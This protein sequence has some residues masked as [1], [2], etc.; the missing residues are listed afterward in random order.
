[1]TVQIDGHVLA[2]T[3][4]AGSVKLSPEHDTL[5]DIKVTNNG[6]VPV[7]VRTLRL[8]GQVMGLQFFAYNTGVGAT[9]GA[10]ETESRQ[11]LL[12]LS[13]LNDQA[14]GFM[15]GTVKAVDA[16]HHVVAEQHGLVDVRGSL[17]S[18][19][20]LF[21]LSVALLTALLFLEV[22]L[23]LARELLPTNRWRRATRF[24]TPGLGLGLVINFTLAATR[25]FA[26][27]MGRWFG[28]AVVSAVAMFV[29]GYLTPTPGTEAPE[30]EGD[31]IE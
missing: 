15:L 21:G 5:L 4:G 22:L 27:G 6:P 19:Y 20:G 26:P 28:I 18:V 31:P 16:D 7:T 3:T 23:A 24:L 10:S 2:S 17:Q 11:L 30:P 13:G 25:V 9:V 14:T 12:D 29:L 1:M 8:E